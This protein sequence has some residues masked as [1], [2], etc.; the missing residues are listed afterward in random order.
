MNRVSR[1][2]LFTGAL[3]L[4]AAGALWSS[5][6]KPVTA[7]TKLSRFGWAWE[8]QGLDDP[9]APSI[10]G[11][12]EGAQYFGLKKAVYMYH[13]NSEAAMQK[14]DRLEEVVCDITKWVS[15]ACGYGCVQLRYDEQ[16]I[17]NGDRRPLDEAR[18]VRALSLTH[19]NIGGAFFDDTLSSVKPKRGAV[20]PEDYA[21]I[22]AELKKGN[23]PLKLWARVHSEQLYAED[24]AGFKPHMDV[25]NLWVQNSKDLTNLDRYVD[26]CRQVFPGKPLVL[27]CYL[28]N[29]PT[30]S[31]MP[32][33]L[34]RLQWERVLNY[35]NAGKIDGYTIFGTY[36]IDAAQE[37]A[38]WVRN[39]IAAN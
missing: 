37:Q 6:A 28:W 16:T 24:W 5:F 26:R 31:P 33:D 14:L 27:G 23:A 8:G 19:H 11:V 32:L 7:P 12:G 39:F 34:L 25:I 4:S 21:S 3:K 18:I 13:P 17:W 2:D 22:N 10:Y 36:L 9:M 35:V 38:R 20:S 15:S 1:R 29:Y 30:K